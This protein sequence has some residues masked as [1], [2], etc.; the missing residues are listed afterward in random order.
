MDYERR[1]TQH[2]RF[3]PYGTHADF[4][5]PKTSFMLGMVAPTFFGHKDKRNL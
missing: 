1:M 2:K 5:L 4:C 3:E